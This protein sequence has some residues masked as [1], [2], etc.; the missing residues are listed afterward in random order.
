ML[1]LPDECESRGARAE[2][3]GW[4]SQVTGGDGAC[5]GG[6]IHSSGGVQRDYSLSR[7]VGTSPLWSYGRS[8]WPI[9]V[10][11]VCS[12]SPWRIHCQYVR[13]H[14]YPRENSAE[15]VDG[16]RL[17]SFP[18]PRLHGSASRGGL[19]L[20]ELYSN[21]LTYGLVSPGTQGARRAPKKHTLGP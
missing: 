19:S 4:R 12:L 18:V 10:W 9:V 20:V 14:L 17:P 2:Q 5:G 7:L 11:C 16:R 1:R 21:P 13:P 3:P 8:G 6:V 15:A